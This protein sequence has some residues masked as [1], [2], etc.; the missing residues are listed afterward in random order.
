MGAQRGGAGV[1]VDVE[2]CHGGVQCGSTGGEKITAGR[3]TDRASATHSPAKVDVADIGG[4]KQ[5]YDAY[6]AWEKRH[7]GPSPTVG[8][9]TPEQLFFVAH[10]QVWCSLYTPEQMRLR[11][12]TDP[13]SPGQFRV[14]GPISNHPAFAAA[15]QCP[16]GSPMTPADRCEVW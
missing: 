8:K 10:G 3:E 6:K 4:L 2:K 14:V 1:D 7:A 9:L 12:T 15:F 16:A 5:S 13:H 11:I